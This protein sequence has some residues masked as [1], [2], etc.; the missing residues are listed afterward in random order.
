MNKINL[1]IMKIDFSES[2]QTQKY[3]TTNGEIKK[4]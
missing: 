4:N 3:L 2:N 1:N